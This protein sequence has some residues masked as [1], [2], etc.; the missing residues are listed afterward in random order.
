MN[1]SEWYEALSNNETAL[2]HK[3]DADVWTN[4]LNAA[5]RDL[6][7]EYTVLERSKLPTVASGVSI[8]IEILKNL[9]EDKS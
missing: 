7:K 2:L 4:A 8:S 1:F 3:H 9:L 6:K 5:I